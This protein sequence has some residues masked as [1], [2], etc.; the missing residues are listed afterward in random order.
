[1]EVKVW[2]LWVKKLTIFQL[3]I[4]C[5]FPA[6]ESHSFPLPFS[7]THTQRQ[8]KTN[9]LWHSPRRGFFTPPHVDKHLQMSV[10]AWDSRHRRCLRCHRLDP[11]LKSHLR[12]CPIPFSSLPTFLPLATVMCAQL[13]LRCSSFC[14]QIEIFN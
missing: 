9:I 10:E 8:R 7:H 5:N 13:E 11:Q 2:L 4:H 14:S 1:M 6:G 3:Y 12:L